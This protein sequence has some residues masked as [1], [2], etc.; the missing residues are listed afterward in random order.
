MLDI[1]WMDALRAE[2]AR[3]VGPKVYRLAELTRLGIGV[4]L[5]FA[6]PATWFS[7][8]IAVPCVAETI[9]TTLSSLRCEG[10]VALAAAAARIGECIADAPFPTEFANAIDAAYDT[11]CARSQSLVRV[12]VRSSGICED[13]AAASFAGQY[14]TLL[15]VAGA[16]AVRAAVK[17]CW[18]SAFGQG[19][20]SYAARNGV[21]LL[22]APL[23]VGIMTLV[24]ARS[25]GVAFSV[26]PVT[27]NRSRVVIEA[28]W[29]WGEAVVQGVVT[30]DRAEID[31]SD[32]RLLTYHVAHKAVRSTFD[33][34]A[35]RVVLRP[36]PQSLATTRVLDASELAALHRAVVAIEQFYG[37][38]VDVEWAIDERPEIGLMIVQ[39]RPI[40]MLTQATPTTWDPFA[41]AMRHVVSNAHVR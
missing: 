8:F 10:D 16:E 4:P 12:A 18:A 19:A 7:A 33:Y 26:H 24:E 28:N 41:A 36:M 22:D 32:G 39:T 40:T 2:H 6:L 17:T 37:V 14:E 3:V 34:A 13:G 15:G 29:G 9:E 20:I 11:L 38:P 30:P 27:G 1:L 5:G 23:A 31:K 25:A 35:A 21:S